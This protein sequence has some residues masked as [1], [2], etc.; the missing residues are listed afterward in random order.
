MR[1]NEG[2]SWYAVKIQGW[3]VP[4]KLQR[5]CDEDVNAQEAFTARMERQ[6]RQVEQ[7]RQSVLQNEG[8]YLSK[9]EAAAEWV[10][11]FAE[12]FARDN[13]NP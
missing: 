9:D 8:R 3:G 2:G 13:D 4:M 6:C 10:E 11:Q 12:V 5:Q 1:A 7:Y